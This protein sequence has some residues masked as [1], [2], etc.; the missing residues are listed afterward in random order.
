MNHFI[1]VINI[2]EIML[3]VN[4]KDMENTFGIKIILHIEEILKMD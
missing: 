1:M 2:V 3:M 4:L